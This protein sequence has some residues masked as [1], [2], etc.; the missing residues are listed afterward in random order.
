MYSRRYDRILDFD[1]KKSEHELL[2]EY[3]SISFKDC[4]EKCRKE[5]GVFGYNDG[6]MK[7]R[8]HKKLHKTSVS[9]QAGWRYF[10]HDFIPTDC[11]NLR[12]D[13][14]TN[15]GVYEIYPYGTITS[16]VRVYCDMETMDGGWTAIQKRV[17]ESLN[18]RRNWTEYKNGFGS[19]EQNVWVVRKE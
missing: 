13:G 7:C 18:F 16:P 14:H 9:D 1:N 4:A 17:N 5:C 10:F 2:G 11:K 8:T 19:P 3:N 12:K 15:T 6:L